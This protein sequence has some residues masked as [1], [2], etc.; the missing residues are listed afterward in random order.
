[1][2]AVTTAHRPVTEIRGGHEP[3]A[4]QAREVYRFFHAGPEEVLALRGLSLSVG[5]G[6]VLALAGPSGSGKSTLLAVLAGVDD[7]DGG[8]VFVAGQRMSHRREAERS[9]LRRSRIGVLYQSDNLLPHLTVAQNVGLAQQLAR[10]RRDPGP[11]LERVGLG[12][13]GRS[14][15]E[16][17]SGGEAARAGLAVA[18]AGNPRVLLAD[19]PTA[20]LDTAAETRLLSLLRSLA[21]EDGLAIVVATHSG[22]VVA[23][24]D[25]ALPLVDGRVRS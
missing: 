18:L 6:E 20:E 8:Q 22:R 14:L 17:L 7:P 16:Q 1:V 13:R 5:A 19:E 15:P 4:V 21:D 25:R 9:R 2:D 10:R 3:P 12:H 24:A 23:V 11:L